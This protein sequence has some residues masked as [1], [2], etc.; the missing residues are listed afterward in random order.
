VKEASATADPVVAWEATL[1]RLNADIL[2][3]SP[4]STGVVNE[5][6]GVVVAVLAFEGVAVPSASVVGVAAKLKFGGALASAT[7]SGDAEVSTDGANLN[8]AGEF[9]GSAAS[10]DAEDA[11]NVKTLIAID[12]PRDQKKQE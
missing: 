9:G 1:A 10:D 12:A 11:P 7:E 2:S 6:V 4:K 5:N 3:S 8:T